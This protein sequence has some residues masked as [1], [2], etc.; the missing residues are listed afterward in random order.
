M[1]YTVT[2]ATRFRYEGP[3]HESV[4]EVRLGPRNDGR[5]EVQAFELKTKPAA[6][7][8]SYV[9]AFGND[10]HHFDIIPP[11]SGAPRPDADARAHVGRRAP[12]LNAWSPRRGTRWRACVPTAQLWDFFEPSPRVPVSAAVRAFASAC[13]LVRAIRPADIV[14]SHRFGRSR[15]AGLRAR[16]T[17]VDTPIE[18]SSRR[19]A[20]SVRTSRTS[21]S[22][23]CA[24]TAFRA[25]T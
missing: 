7:Y 4:M 20:A 22:R 24:R 1:D 19:V 12:C 23:S 8:F 16:S 13:G 10:V 5:Q 11:A 25:D 18:P 6:A 17:T 2:H 9:D 15:R 21:H 3:V 14:P